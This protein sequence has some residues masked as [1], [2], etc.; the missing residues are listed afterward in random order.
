MT[1]DIIVSREGTPVWSEVSQQEFLLI[2]MSLSYI[3]TSDKRPL[4]S[5]CVWGLFMT[6]IVQLDRVFGCLALSA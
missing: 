2:L 4:H 6:S 5:V 1:M 3:E